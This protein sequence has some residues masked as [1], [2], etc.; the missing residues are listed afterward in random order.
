[1]DRRGFLRATGAAVAVPTTAGCFGVGAD[2]EVAYDVGMST[3][4]YKPETVEVSVGDT[5]VW[6]NTSGTAHTVTAYEAAIPEE[7]SYWASGG[8]ETEETARDA[9]TSGLEGALYES[10]TYERTF[11]VAGEHQYFCVPH[12]VGGMVGTVVVTE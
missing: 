2:P 1:M 5:V 9:W 4:A 8:F 7:A 3:R 11:A 10:E 12:E 6:Q